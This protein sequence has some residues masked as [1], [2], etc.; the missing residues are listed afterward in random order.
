MPIRSI[1]CGLSWCWGAGPASK[2]IAQILNDYVI[3]L[4]ERNNGSGS[5][6]KDDQFVH[7]IEVFGSSPS[8]LCALRKPGNGTVND[9]SNAFTD[10]YDVMRNPEH[11][12]QFQKKVQAWGSR[13]A[14]GEWDFY[15]NP[16]WRQSQDLSGEND[17]VNRAYQ[18]Y[19]VSRAALATDTTAS[20]YKGYADEV[21]RV[22]RGL[23]KAYE[24]LPS[25][26]I[27]PST[28][29]AVAEIIAR[30]D[31]VQLDNRSWRSILKV[32]DRE[33]SCFYVGP[34]TYFAH[35]TGTAAKDC[36]KLV[37]SLL[38]LRGTAVLFGRERAPYARL[39][40]A[41]WEKRKI[42]WSPPCPPNPHRYHVYR[43]GPKL[44]G[45]KPHVLPRFVWI[46]PLK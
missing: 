28:I 27:E 19:C 3:K 38:H 42:E 41:G 46:G 31:L 8:V 11:L 21:D 33:Q 2:H 5:A 12:L 22:R 36:A 1:H 16:I 26:K 18:F 29:D 15:K 9:L 45:R 14:H 13:P 24:M 34:D 44:K 7:Y 32:Y 17:L 37:D 23:I 30:F 43:D 35:N 10:F 39:E 6:K 4:E 40:A 25:P 20:W